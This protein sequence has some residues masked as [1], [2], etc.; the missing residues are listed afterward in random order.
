M[1]NRAYLYSSDRPDDWGRPEIDYY[2]SRWTIPLAWWLFF[3]PGNAVWQD[4]EFNGD[5]WHEIKLSAPKGRAL[6]LFAARRLLLLQLLG[7]GLGEVDV[8]LFVATVAARPG[9]HLIVNPEQVL[10]G[11]SLSDEAHMKAFESAL[12]AVA[13]GEPAE[14]VRATR[15]YVGELGES[16]RAWVFG[17]TYAWEPEPVAAPDPAA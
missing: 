12:A 2:D 4:V 5:H 11:Y 14:V 3:E 16:A 7:G 13:A 9:C 10:G 17:Y 8:D 1:A 15:E 6:E